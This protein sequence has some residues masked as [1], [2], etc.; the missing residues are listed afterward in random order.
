[1]L[2]GCV[3]SPEYLI[4]SV[5]EEELESAKKE[6]ESTSV[7]RTRAFGWRKVSRLQ[8]VISRLENPSKKICYALEENT[9]PSGCNWEI[10]YNDDPSINAFATINRNGLN[11]VSINRG[12]LDYAKNEDELALL[13]AHEIAHHMANHI[14]EK[15]PNKNTLGE[16]LGILVGLAILSSSDVDITLDNVDTAINIVGTTKAIGSE[17]S[18]Y[19]FTRKQEAEADLIAIQLIDDAGYNVEKSKNFFLTLFAS[20]ENNEISADFFDTHPSG[21]SRIAAINKSTNEKNRSEII[22]KITNWCSKQNI[23]DRWK[24]C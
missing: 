15:L 5:S 21:P 20:G 3:S 17:L 18:R 23:Y 8:K 14:V 13:V 6:I 11:I 12:V 19:K 2:V 9:S 1:M 7:K 24:Y 16:G 4:D 10:D 22:Q